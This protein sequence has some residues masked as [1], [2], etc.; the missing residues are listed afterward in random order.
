MRGDR[1]KNTPERLIALSVPEL[2]KLLSKLME[3]AGE[4]LEQI[5]SWPYWRRRHQYRA[6]QCHYHSRD[7]PL[8][9]KQLR[10]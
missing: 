8:I 6:Q 9:K 10:L 5:L 2:R 3:K 1:R 4:T 7:N